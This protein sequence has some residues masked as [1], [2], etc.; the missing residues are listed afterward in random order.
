MRIARVKPKTGTYYHI[1][2]RV[3]GEPGWYPFGDVERQKFVDLVEK[4]S[5]L[6]TVEVLAYQTMGNHYHILCYAPAER[7]S[8]AEA[9]ARHNA[10]A[11]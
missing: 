3:A 4:F 8:V 1:I 5:H 7:L 9:V 11:N 10:F 6:F 2:N